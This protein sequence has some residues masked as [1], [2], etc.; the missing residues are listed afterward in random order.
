M[1]GIM[2]WSSGKLEKDGRAYEWEEAI[3]LRPEAF[4]TPSL[5]KTPSMRLL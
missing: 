3:M 5:D 2:G 1:M 4:G